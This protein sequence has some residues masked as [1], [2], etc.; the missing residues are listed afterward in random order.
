MLIGDN[1]SGVL[2]RIAEG[3]GIIR[4]QGE[5]VSLNKLRNDL[6]NAEAF[7]EGY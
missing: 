2:V 7:K 5:I 6:S 1:R 4:I 3:F